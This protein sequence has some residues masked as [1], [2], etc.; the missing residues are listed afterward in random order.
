VTLVGN[1]CYRRL[2]RQAARLRIVGG[3]AGNLLDRWRPECVIAE[4]RLFNAALS[5]KF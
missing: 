2:E 1:G 4:I 3:L 5:W